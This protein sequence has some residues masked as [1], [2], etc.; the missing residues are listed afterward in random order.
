MLRNGGSNCYGYAALFYE[1]AR[2]LGYDARI[3]SGIVLGEQRVF[4]TE[5]GTRVISPEA[6]TPHGWVEIA[7]DG[8]DYIF[9]PEYEYRSSGL[10]NMFM[11][12]EGIRLQYGYMK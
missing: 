11:A 9:D 12:D 10:Q 3:Y 6:Y 2:F 5:E 4:Y 7:F 8:V 1:L